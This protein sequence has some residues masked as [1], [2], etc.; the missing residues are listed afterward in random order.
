M[1][2]RRE[3]RR[4][5][6]RAGVRQR[7]Q[8]RH[9]HLPLRPALRHGTALRPA[10]LRPRPV[11]RGGPVP[12]RLLQRLQR[13]AVRRPPLSR[14]ARGLLGTRHVQ[15][16]DS[17]VP[18][19]A[20]L[21]RRSVP[22]PAVPRDAAVQRR[23]RHLPV[24]AWRGP[25]AL[26]RLR[27]PAHRG[28][29]R[30]AVRSRV[31]RA[32]R[33]RELGVPVPRLLQRRQL[34]RRVLGSREL[35]RHDRHLRLRLRGRA[36]RPVRRGRVSRLGRGLLGPRG[37]QLR[38]GPVHVRQ[39][40][41]RPRLRQTLVPQ[42][43]SLSGR[44]RCRGRPAG[45]S[46]R[47]G[48]LRRRLRIPVRQRD[49][50]GQGMPL[51]AVLLRTVLRHPLLRHWQLHRQRDLRL[52]LRRRKGRLL[53]AAWLSRVRQRLQRQRHVQHGDRGVRVFG[54][55]EGTRLR[56]ARLHRQLQ[57]PRRVR[58]LRGKPRVQELP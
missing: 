37:L 10:V 49:H 38:H 31:S 43:L 27:F 22:R 51:P 39:R 33:G 58:Q 50:R 1:R 16:G 55:M 12:V 47:A 36:R 53:P 7:H 45:V 41:E 40:L 23:Q 46:L 17:R 19:R 28:R 29:V 18:V 9:R 8:P 56:A 20:R 54:G 48:L 21:E 44:L 11:R 26:L 25:A 34:R 4:Q 57:R 30:A 24:G 52:R 3:I 35:Q 15:R 5:S 6:L 32:V 2:L 42:Q 13:P 14:V